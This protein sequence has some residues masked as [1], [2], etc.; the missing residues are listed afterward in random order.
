VLHATISANTDEFAGS[1]SST[2]WRV[3][4]WAPELLPAPPVPILIDGE[5]HD[6]RADLEAALDQ[7]DQLRDCLTRAIKRLT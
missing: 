2:P 6:L 3:M 5:V 1:A 7:L 4:S